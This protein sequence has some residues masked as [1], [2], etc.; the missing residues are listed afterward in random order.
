MSEQSP[1]AEAGEQE[2]PV[3]AIV[4]LLAEPATLSVKDIV[5]AARRA[6]GLQLGEEEEGPDGMVVEMR[7]S[8]ALIYTNDWLFL[9]NYFDRPYV[10]DPESEAEKIQEL[11]TKH[12]FRQHVAWISCDVF[13]RLTDEGVQA[14][15]EGDTE[16]YRRLGQLFTE[17][18]PASTLLLYLPEY[19]LFFA[20]NDETRSALRAD[21][22]L[23][24][25]VEANEVPVV[26]V[27]ENH[28]EMLRAQEEARRTWPQ[29]VA[30]FEQKRG[31]A[32]SIKA[33][34]GEGENCEFIWVQVEA[35][36]GD[37]IYG[38]L[39]NPPVFQ[40]NLALG[41]QVHVHLDHLNDWLYLD[42][43]GKPVGG[44]TIRVLAKL[45]GYTPPGFETE[46]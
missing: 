8:T 42:E 38:K 43:N 27:T 1:T 14:L 24:A 15:A 37:W 30:A 26:P 45:S 29:F 5:E 9:V 46:S 34:L 16:I 25:L 7:P 11:R 41:S 28:P 40:E 35:I 12:L 21:D 33:P 32:F 17:L 20:V 44:Y 36:E 23:E 39:A 13:G 10:E 22:P 31:S 18:M 3:I 19:E 6:W 4:G 2:R